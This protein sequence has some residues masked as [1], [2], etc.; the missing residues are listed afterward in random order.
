MVFTK[1]GALE[2]AEIFGAKP[3]VNR[4]ENRVPKFNMWFL[5]VFTMCGAL[6]SAEIFGATLIFLSPNHA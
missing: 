1:C 6:E 4:I 2:S 5:M 3:T